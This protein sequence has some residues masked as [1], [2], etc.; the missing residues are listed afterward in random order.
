MSDLL[1]YARA[2]DDQDFIWRIAA[3]M[4]VRAQETEFWDLPVNERSLVNWTLN[5]PMTAPAFMINH[6]STNSSI[7][8][9]ITVENGTVTTSGIPDGDIQFVVNEKWARVANSMFT[10][11]APVGKRTDLVQTRT[12]SPAARMP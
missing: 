1:K 9:N 12:E 8:A 4:M 11:A 6:V 10:E 2:R 7:A 5:N 3:A